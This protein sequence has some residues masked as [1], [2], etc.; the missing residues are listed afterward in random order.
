MNDDNDAA[1][2][3]QLSSTLLSSLSSSSRRQPLPR[4]AV[5]LAPSSQSSIRSSISVAESARSSASKLSVHIDIDDN[6]Q[7]ARESLSLEFADWDKSCKMLNIDTDSSYQ[8][9]MKT[10][11]KMFKTKLKLT[12]LQFKTLMSTSMSFGHLH[13]A[14]DDNMSYLLERRRPTLVECL[15]DRADDDPVMVF[16]RSECNIEY[17][18]DVDA[19]N[20]PKKLNGAMYRKMREDVKDDQSSTY[21]LA[22]EALQIIELNREFPLVWMRGVK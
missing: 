3:A 14:S 18:S 21:T 16:L 20:S 15:E 22:Y 12:I 1:A 11:N 2:I 17:G 7:Y 13:I 10:Y 5:E 6:R 4:S 8:T 19:S 9:F